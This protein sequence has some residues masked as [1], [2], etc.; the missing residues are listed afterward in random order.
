MILINSCHLKN[1][2]SFLLKLLNCKGFINEMVTPYL[3]YHSETIN[4]HYLSK[5]IIINIKTIGI[6]LVKEI[7]QVNGI[8]EQGK[9]LFNA[10]LKRAKILSFFYQHLSMFDRHGG[11]CA[12]A[13]FCGQ[14]TNIDGP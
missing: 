10:Q 8:D 13:H 6:D 1:I 4:R 3:L 2:G 11:L 14:K 7:F 5:A 9:R 12:S